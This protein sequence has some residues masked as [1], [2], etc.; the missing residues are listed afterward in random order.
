V[1]PTDD[2]P[3][4]GDPPLDEALA[5]V[6]GLGQVEL[7]EHPAVLRQAVEALQQFLRTGPSAP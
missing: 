4:T 1:N 7:S 6:A 3:V 5:Q 2:V